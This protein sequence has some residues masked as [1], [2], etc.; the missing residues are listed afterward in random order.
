MSVLR[1]ALQ[2]SL[3]DLPFMERELRAGL[4]PFLKPPGEHAMELRL[5][6]VED[7]EAVLAE[8]RGGS[9]APLVLSAFADLEDA[10]H[11]HRVAQELWDAGF[12]E[13][14]RY[15]VARQL[16]LIEGDGLMV[17]EG[18]PGIPL[19]KLVD[20]RATEAVRQVNE[21][22]AWLGRMHSVD[23]RVGSPWLPWRSV[24][25]LSVHLRARRRV[26]DAHRETFRDMVKRLAPLAG[27]ASK[28][29]WVQTHGRFRPDRV[30]AAPGALTVDDFVRSCPGDP[31]RDIA[32]FVVHLRRR[33]AFT[34]EI[35]ADALEPAFLDGYLANA[36]D[37]PL[38]NVSF[39]AGCAVLTSMV[40]DAPSLTVDTKEWMDW[41][42]GEFD[43]WVMPSPIHV[44]LPTA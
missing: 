14:S 10:A 36:S 7:R 19:V 29:T 3:S 33:A 43:R 21:T 35:R 41:H 5:V 31:A 26:V 13:R 1:D 4:S 44:L 39:Y 9:E 6:D 18:T 34:D 24:E 32:E 37:E 27:R 16:A 11:A 15:R 8:L 22:G 23:F 25:A 40:A 42:R 17:S 2:A 20:R 28:W 38:D 30:I 12:D